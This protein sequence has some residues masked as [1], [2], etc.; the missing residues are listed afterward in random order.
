MALD[1]G[2]HGAIDHQYAVFEFLSDISHDKSKFKIK[3]SKT[4]RSTKF[5]MLKSATQAKPN[6]GSN[7]YLQDF[8]F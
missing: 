7:A 2:A 4:R 6:Q 8:P 1:H 5:Q 3:K